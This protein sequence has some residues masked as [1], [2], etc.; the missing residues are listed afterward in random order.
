LP[1][2]HLA[3]DSLH[4]L[5]LRIALSRKVKIAVMTGLPAERYVKVQSSHGL[6]AA[7][8]SL[9]LLWL[10]FGVAAQPS[11]PVTITG[12]A[13]EVKRLSEWNAMPGSQVDSA[14]I[15]VYAQRITDIFR[16]RGYWLCEVE[17]GIRNDTV[18]VSIASG[19]WFEMAAL[20]AGNL[21][22]WVRSE[23]RFRES[24]LT[25]KPVEVSAVTGLFN[26][27]IGVS[28][29]NGYPFA[30]VR[31]D[32]VSIAG[33]RISA[34]LNYNPGPLIVFDTIDTGAER[35][36]KALW[37]SVYADMKPGSPYSERRLRELPE[38]IRST[39]F[40]EVTESP[41][42]RFQDLRARAFVN[43]KVKKVSSFDGWLGLLPGQDKGNLL[44]TGQIDMKLRN[45]FR[46]GKSLDMFWQRYQAESQTVRLRYEHPVLLQSPVGLEAGFLL[47]KEE[48]QFLNRD[49][50]GGINWRVAR[51]TVL[52][53]TL[54][55]FSSDRLSA[56]PPGEPARGEI[57][58][59]YYGLRLRHDRMNDPVM[60][61]AGYH[62][63]LEGQAGPRTS[64]D[65]SGA[66]EFRTTQASFR[67]QARAFV[68]VRGRWLFYGRLEGAALTGNGLYQNELFRLGGLQT[69]RGFNENYFYAGRY[70]FG[71]AEVRYIAEPGTWLAV[72]LDGGWIQEQRDSE[73]KGVVPV[74][75]GLSF[76]V[77]TK[78]GVLALALGV[79]RSDKDGFDFDQAKLHF[80]YQARF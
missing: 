49:L 60:P 72:F 37:L 4:Q 59:T 76:Q 75:T 8:V 17:A 6:N 39:G 78:G 70:T 12:K 67:F 31:L 34:S 33:T 26:E 41:V 53:A 10:S 46:S 52:A 38:V 71:T 69:I 14:E 68:P 9:C 1:D 62:W 7:K 44:I 73:T 28:E 48:N 24:A 20:S 32:S 2:F 29:N 18:R 43:L 30:S 3:S 13:E 11:F 25:G 42:V 64:A 40:L 58:T 47:L 51:R 61:T 57:N 55:S 21:P 77:Q 65:S 15:S 19:P 50:T 22:E 56:E 79:G 5:P 74:G 36:V 63:T 80:G 23:L 27:V 16:D 35:R 54:K 45:L 66:P